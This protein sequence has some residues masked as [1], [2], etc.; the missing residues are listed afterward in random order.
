MFQFLVY[1]SDFLQ[2]SILSRMDFSLMD[3]TVHTRP[4]R[5]ISRMNSKPEPSISSMTFKWEEVDALI[6]STTCTCTWAYHVSTAIQQPLL[7]SNN[8]PKRFSCK[9]GDFVCIWENHSKWMLV[10]WTDGIILSD[11]VFAQSFIRVT[12]PI[13]STLKSASTRSFLQ[14]FILIPQ[15][16]FVWRTYF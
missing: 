2:S 13:N 1:F 4:D 16:L 14:P 6:T 10:V 8:F 11:F 7:H 12:H 15:N 5:T 3:S 9:E